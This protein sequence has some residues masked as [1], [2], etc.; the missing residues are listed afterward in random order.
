MAQRLTLHT[1]LAEIDLAARENASSIMPSE[2]SSGEE[3]E[4]LYSRNRI[5]TESKV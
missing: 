1:C 3:L 5:K 2:K 4:Q